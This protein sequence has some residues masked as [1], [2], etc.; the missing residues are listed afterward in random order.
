MSDPLLEPLLGRVK[1]PVPLWEKRITLLENEV[2]ALHGRLGRAYRRIAEL[3]GGD[4]QLALDQL[5][6]DL[7]QAEIERQRRE[8]AQL[9]VEAKKEAQKKK[10]K[11]RPQ[12]G[13]GPREQSA[14]PVVEVL[15]ELSALEAVCPVCGGQAEPMGD[16][17]E[18]SEDIHVI[19]RQYVKRRIR[20]RKYRCRCN[21][22][23]ITAPGPLRVLAGGRY[24]PEFMLQVAADKWLD[25]V[26]LERQVRIMARHGLEVS[27]QTLFDQAQALAELLRPI[28]T[29][30]GQRVLQAPVLHADETRWPRLDARES[31]P[32]TVWTRTTPEIAHYAILPSKSR[33]AADTLFKGYRGTIVVD[34]YQV[35]E[36]LARDGPDLVL[37][38]CWAHVR[39]KFAEIRENFPSACTCVLK[40]IRC[41]YDIEEQVEGP[42]PGDAEVQ[43]QR[44]ALRAEHSQALIDEIW[45]WACTTVGLPRSE[46]GKAVRYMIKRKKAL[47]RFLKDPRIPLDNNAA[48]RSL[49]GPVVGRKVHYGSKSKRGTEVAAIFYT[50]FE[51]AKLCGVEPVGY[52]R[53]ATVQILKDPGSVLLPHAFRP[54]T[55]APSN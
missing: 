31:S 7:K 28:Y 47:T 23:V 12:R 10:R 36:S 1:D 2:Q 49:R 25:H 34:G 32:W 17:F 24:S 35:Y 22:C 48:E 52:L 29:E 41:L 53:Q 50:L 39:R 51:T 37:A 26:P 13:H 38:N 54:P 16:Q 18:Q 3:E 14:L 6:E 46:L 21:A 40:K 42:F 20:R 11:E 8:Q 43:R 19:E 27:S 30:L 33:K 55:E 44:A 5:I 45:G 15:G 4:P 9:E